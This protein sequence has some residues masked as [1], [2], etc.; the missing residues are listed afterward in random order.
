MN[1][2]QASMSTMNTR[3]S[4]SLR[5]LGSSSSDESADLFS[6]RTAPSIPT[7]LMKELVAFEE[8]GTQTKVSEALHITQPAVTR[9]LR[10][11]E[12]ILGVHLFDRQPNRTSLTPVGQAAAQQCRVLLGEYRSFVESVRNLE[13]ISR[14]LVIGGVIPGP[15]M[16]TRRLLGMP[17]SL[18]DDSTVVSHHLGPFGRISVIG[19]LI[20]ASDVV[21]GLDES[22]YEL[23]LT[24]DEIFTDSIESAYL[25]PE[26]L[27]VCF[28]EFSPFVS[29]NSITLR[30]L[31]GLTFLVAG[32][33][34]A[35]RD[36]IEKNI[37]DSKFVYQQD[38]NSMQLLASSSTL[39]TFLSN[40]S[41]GRSTDDDR[42]SIPVE[43]PGGRLDIYA[44]YEVRNKRSVAPF[45]SSLQHQWPQKAVRGH[46]GRS[47]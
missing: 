40:L 47:E 20:S 9:G 11:F 6:D 29:R 19:P 26:R 27:S 37:P 5:G 24:N 45:I 39:P 36:V 18:K 14:T 31:A 17:V 22:R 33:I 34:G 38:L 16:L 23:V 42:V 44:T 12:S 43:G 1:N 10:Q 35:W 25:G 7:I 8:L 15:L 32:Q 28:N 2:R 30:E 21:R 41:A 4:A 13:R 46:R 3:E